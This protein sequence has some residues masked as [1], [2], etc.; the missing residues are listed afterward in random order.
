MKP[1]PR[2][3][4]REFYEKTGIDVDGRRELIV[5]MIPYLEEGIRRFICLAKA[6]PGFKELPVDDQIGLLKSKYTG[7]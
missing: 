5:S 1:I 3:E 4:Y 6:V 7:Q 2:E